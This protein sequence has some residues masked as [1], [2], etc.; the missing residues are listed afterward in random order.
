MKLLLSEFVCG[1]ATSLNLFSEGYA[2]LKTLY[3]GF[4]EFFSEVSVIVDS[5]V[6]KHCDFEN[7]IESSGDFFDVILDR[8]SDF[9]YCLIIA[10]ESDGVLE[11][12]VTL[13]KCQFLG[14]KP[15]AIALCADKFKTYEIANNCGVLFP[16]TYLSNDTIDLN[17]PF[18]IKNRDGVGCDGIRLTHEIPSQKDVIV[19]EYIEGVDVSLSLIVNDD[20]INNIGFNKQDIIKSDHFEYVGGYTPF[21]HHLRHDCIEIAEKLCSNIPGLS[22]WIGIDF[23]LSDDKVY[24]IEINPRPT[25]P[26]VACSSVYGINPS[27]A[28]FNAC[29]SHNLDLKLKNN[30]VFHFKKKKRYE[31]SKNDVILASNMSDDSAM[32]VASYKV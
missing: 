25:T 3:D 32:F 22:G 2:M 17:P 23:V 31:L 10:P 15:Q 30:G 1:S 16:K 9:D 18:L 11:K 26:I 5:S 21:E 28:I 8:S 12:C 4:C 27:L 14:P 24:F 6:S 29:T 20:K 13:S 19:Q 7:K